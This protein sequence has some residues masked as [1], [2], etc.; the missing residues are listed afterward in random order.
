MRQPIVLRRFSARSRFLDTSIYRAVDTALGVADAVDYWTSPPSLR[1]EAGA[2]LL[3]MSE[4][5][6]VTGLRLL[7]R[8]PPEDQ[9]P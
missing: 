1:R 2:K 9:D 4:W 7:G 5:S 8:P 6:L 3:A